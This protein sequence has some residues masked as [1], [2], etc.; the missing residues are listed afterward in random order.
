MLTLATPA[1]QVGNF[2]IFL[3]IFTAAA[4]KPLT[5]PES[6]DYRGQ[7]HWAASEKRMSGR[8]LAEKRTTQQ[9]MHMKTTFALLIGLA[10]AA[11]LGTASAQQ[12]RGRG[13]AGQR[14]P[15]QRPPAQEPLAASQF[16]PPIATLFDK[17]SNAVLSPA[18]ISGAA[19]ALRAV[20]ANKDGQVTKE[21]LC[22]A[23][24]PNGQDC[25]ALQGRGVGARQPRGFA[26]GKGQAKGPGQSPV[27]IALLDTD[28]D[29]TLSTAEINNSPAV[30]GKLDA[31]ADAQLTPD[32]V[33]P[34][35]GRGRGPRGP[36]CP[37]PGANCPV[38]GANCPVQE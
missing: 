25:P 19:D 17:D 13:P 32:E 18:E 38:Q 35:G 11:S 16:P 29:G 1:P 4:N 6:I 3:T 7:E 22:Q 37:M 33:R 9:A 26:A 5:V 34:M 15:Q 28:K 20:D 10:L 21:E 23:V 12:G 30:L 14:P 24:C 36:N 8:N 2:Y 31:N 27:V